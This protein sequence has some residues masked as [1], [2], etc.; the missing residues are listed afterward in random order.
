V[1]VQTLWL[2]AP[3]AVVALALGVIPGVPPVLSPDSD[4]FPDLGDRLFADDGNGDPG[5][6]W[7]SVDCVT[8]ARVRTANGFR[9]LRVRDGD[10]YFG[11][12]CELGKND[13]R[14]GP[15]ALYH[16][17]EHRITVF[18]MRLGRHFPISHYRWQT[19]MQM[20]Q[21]QPYTGD[22][23][24]GVALDLQ[25][26][27]GRWRLLHTG[28]SGGH[29]QIWSV[30][31]TRG[32]WTRFAFDVVY[33]SHPSRGS[34]RVYVDRN[35]D[36][37]ANDGRERSREF[38]MATLKR[39]QFGSAEGGLAAGASIPSHLRMGIY[40]DPDYYCPGTKCSLAIDDIGIY[41]P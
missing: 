29:K 17:G 34:L 14:S 18:S 19:V 38:T 4:G 5:A 26:F 23:A 37:D 30:P 22:G 32:Q 20:K 3:L 7:G 41:S 27:D 31:A 11:E 28:G 24:F 2:A 39:D 36:G 33:S 8:N 12:R 9:K 1:R 6:V 25:A 13:S 21:A 35:G 16:E 15:T 40:H 10:D